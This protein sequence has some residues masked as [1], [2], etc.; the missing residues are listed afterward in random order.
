LSS[1]HGISLGIK[2]NP[3][4]LGT[5]AKQVLFTSNEGFSIKFGH[6]VQEP[7]QSIS[8]S[9]PFHFPSL[10]NVEQGAHIP[11]QSIPV[12]FWFLILSVQ[13]GTGQAGQVPPQSTPVSFPFRVWS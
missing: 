8:S 13:L 2:S 9:S 4:G 5:P 1:K 6:G 7:P 12:S 10:H 11:P 3:V